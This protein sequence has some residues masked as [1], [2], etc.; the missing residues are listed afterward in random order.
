[1]H[2]KLIREY[3]IDGHGMHIG[4]PFGYHA[5]LLTGGSVST[6][7]NNAGCVNWQPDRSIT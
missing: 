3:I 5:N 4:E 2:E 1:M 7:S 6:Y